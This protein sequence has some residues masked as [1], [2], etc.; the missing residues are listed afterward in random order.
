MARRLQRAARKIMMVRAFRARLEEAV[1]ERTMAEVE[2]MLEGRGAGGGSVARGRLSRCR[3]ARGA[4]TRHA[5]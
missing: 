2:A 4:S 1:G 3:G 5:T